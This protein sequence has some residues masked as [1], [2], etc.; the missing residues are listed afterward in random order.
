MWLSFHIFFHSPLL[1]AH[2]FSPSVTNCPVDTFYLHS[3][4]RNSSNLSSIYYGNPSLGFNQQQHL[5]IFF[6]LFSQLMN[7][8]W[9]YTASV[10]LLQ[11]SYNKRHKRLSS[12][13]FQGCVLKKEKGEEA[14]IMLSHRWRCRGG[15]LRAHQARWGDPK[16]TCTHSIHGCTH[17]YMAYHGLD[18]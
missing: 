5:L 10:L 16:N 7:H 6:I 11:F 2:C 12:T 4:Q 3:Y 1:P 17:E 13:S 15:G 14:A 9:W 18:T 8:Q